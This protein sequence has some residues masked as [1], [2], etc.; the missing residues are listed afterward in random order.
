[1]WDTQAFKKKPSIRNQNF[2]MQLMINEM[3]LENWKLWKIFHLRKLSYRG[4]IKK[5][6]IL[7]WISDEIIS[8]IAMPLICFYLNLWQCTNGNYR[9]IGFSIDICSHTELMSFNAEC[10]IRNIHNS[11]FR[12]IFLHYGNC[13]LSLMNEM[14]IFYANFRI[15]IQQTCL[16]ISLQKKKKR[17]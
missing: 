17:F 13:R 2:K 16:P 5:N 6:Y 4:N 15:I 3:Q 12:C 7:R 10:S 8:L 14:E 1:M 9:R 11:G